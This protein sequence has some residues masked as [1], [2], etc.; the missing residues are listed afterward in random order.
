MS[1]T[2]HQTDLVSPIDKVRVDYA[3]FSGKWAMG[4]VHQLGDGAEP[5]R[6]SWSMYGV[7]G[8]PLGLRS[9]GRAATLEAAKAQFE[10]SRRQWL[11]WAML[12]ELSLGKG[13]NAPED[14]PDITH[15]FAAWDY[16]SF[17]S[18][19]TGGPDRRGHTGRY[20]L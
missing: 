1:L 4:R 10:A 11:E 5:L 8:K 6:W 17:S 15:V 3:V 20:G 2:Y 13:R 9:D 16:R 12:R 14:R 18:V 19:Q 7:L